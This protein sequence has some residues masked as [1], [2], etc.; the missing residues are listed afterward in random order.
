MTI[1][2]GTSKQTRFKRQSAKGSLAGTSDGQILRRESSIFE[3]VK[4]AYSTENEITSKKQLLSNRH[5]VKTVNGRVSGL[6]SPGTY[7][8]IISAVVR[9][10]FAA[11][12]DITGA[13]ITIAGSGPYT[14]TRAAGSFLTDGIKIG[15]VV[16]LTAGSF[17][18]ANLNKNLLVTGVTAL[19]LTVVVLNGSTLTAEG[20]IASATVSVPGK[21]TYIPETGHTNIYYTVEE[22]YSDASISERNLDVKFTEV[23]F[24]L[25][26]SG[27]A[28]I[29]MTAI[30]LDQSDDTSA[31][32]SS[33]SAETTTDV[34]AA[35]NGALYV[36]GTAQATITDLSISINGNG[37]PADGVV[38]TNI[39]PD[40]FV[41]KVM[42]SGSFTAYF[43]GGTIPDVFRDETETSI[44]SALTASSAAAADFITFTISE[45]KLN[46][47]T[48]DD[49]ETG[50]KRTYNFVG[51]YNASG[52]AAL[53]NTATTI[54]IQDSQAA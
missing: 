44:V 42:V 2:Q 36:G 14:V 32:F 53:A 30:G 12:S 6:L 27:N 25:P 50:L 41:G 28:T 31:Y 7:A 5:G 35:A 20:P 26:G 13:S 48:P 33:P 11:V 51:T 24:S 37:S 29:E 3:L 47:S 10:D 46:T 39:R 52:G 21:V 1:A 8:D 40:V 23:N 45:L 4:D 18:A 43:E 15:M 9:R 38:G 19:V 16:R 17:N 49:A 22:W 34:L 54:Q